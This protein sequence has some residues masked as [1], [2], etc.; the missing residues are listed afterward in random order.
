MTRYTTSVSSI[1]AAS[2]RALNY[3]PEVQA[4]RKRLGSGES[5]PLGSLVHGFG[6]G[7]GSVFR[8]VLADPGKGIRLLS[9]REMFRL[10]PDGKWIDPSC[11]PSLEAHQIQK[12]QVLIAGTGTLGPT[13]LYGRAVLVDE[14]LVGQVVGP[15]A[16]V[17]SFREPASDDALCC[18]AFLCSRFGVSAVRSTSYGTKLL[19]PRQ[20]LLRDLPVPLPQPELRRRI[21]DEVRRCVGARETFAS[22]LGE[23]H[24][25]LETV[26]GFSEALHLCGERERRWV[27]WRRSLP[28]LSAWNYASLGEAG[29]LLR[30]RWSRRLEDC[31]EQDGL[32]YG[33]LRQR[34]PS[35]R[36]HGLPLITQRDAMSVRQVPEWIAAPG[37]PTRALVSR[38]NSLVIPGRGT[39]GEGELFGRAVYIT[40][41]L[42]RFALTQDLLRVNPL[43]ADVPLLHLLLRSLLGK[44][45]VRSAAVGTK[46]LQLR[47]D[48]LRALPVPELS[49]QAQESLS[50]AHGRAVAALDESFLREEEAVRIMEQEVLPQWLE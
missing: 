1:T 13:E 34:T 33:L 6:D 23:A 41:R 46:V 17:L 50:A 49:P 15:D 25:T 9:Q 29:E 32:Y 24:T 5:I 47:L 43:T 35:S 26:P 22:A 19:R 40:P 16:L 21:A 4:F 20:D 27:S 38:A 18:Y 31:I 14:R 48:L 42:S 3:A 45:L 2:L 37:V 44:R 10:E 36:A 39:L 8:S 28:T 11:L 30:K 12:W 7:Y